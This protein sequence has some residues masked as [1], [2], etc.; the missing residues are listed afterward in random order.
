M[1]FYCDKCGLCCRNVDKVPQ[2]S[3]FN[4]GNGSCIYLKGNLCSIY[5]KRPEI[6]NVDL[7][8]EKYFE[9]ILSKEE[10][11]QLNYSGC[12]KLK[13]ENKKQGIFID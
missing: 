12:R 11:Y 1:N 6:C 10:F 13:S 2:L 3:A 9:D 5:E 4:S 8:Y 7:M